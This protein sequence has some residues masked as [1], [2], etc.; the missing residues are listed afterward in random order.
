[1]KLSTER[2]DVTSPLF[3]LPCA[4]GSLRRATRVLTRVYDDALGPSGL[5]ITQFGLLASIDRLGE[6]TQRQLSVGLA[7]D[8][9]T[10][11]RTLGLLER[12]GWVV[13]SPGR[14]KRHRILRLT[15][16]G[17]ARLAL[18]RPL[19][20]RAQRDVYAVIGQNTFETLTRMSHD[21][22]AALHSAKGDH[23]ARQRKK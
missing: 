4:C 17:R 7:M 23:A 16:T 1:M 12:R 2:I 6:A 11:T 19:W 14:D 21:I 22:V 9:T 13:R 8:T 3:G 18:A 5:E 20:H 10:L 15:R